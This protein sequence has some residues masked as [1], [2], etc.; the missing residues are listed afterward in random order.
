LVAKNKIADFNDSSATKSGGYPNPLV[1][2]DGKD[3]VEHPCI[4]NS[5]KQIDIILV[6]GLNIKIFNFL[7]F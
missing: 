5:F 2:I 6:I 1:P 4:F 7:K 3:I